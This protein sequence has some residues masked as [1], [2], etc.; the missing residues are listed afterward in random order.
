MSQTGRKVNLA[1]PATELEPGYQGGAGQGAYVVAGHAVTSGQIPRLTD[2]EKPPASDAL[3]GGP[4]A[5]A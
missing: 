1:A 3:G 4:P 2:F 5:Y